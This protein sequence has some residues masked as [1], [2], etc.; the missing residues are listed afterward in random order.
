MAACCAACLVLTSPIAGWALAQE[1]DPLGRPRQQ[2]PP[3]ET[4]QRRASSDASKSDTDSH[5]SGSTTGLPD[6]P[7]SKSSNSSTSSLRDFVPEKLNRPQLPTQRDFAA[8]AAG[9]TRLT[10][11]Q[12]DRADAASVQDAANVQAENIQTTAADGE[13]IVAPHGGFRL[14]KRSSKVWEFGVEIS[15]GNGP[16]RGAIAAAPVP[17]EFP[18]QKITVLSEFRSPQVSSVKMKDFGGQGRQMIVNVPNL[19]PGETARATITMRLDRYD[20]LAPEQPIEWKFAEKGHRDGRLYLG[21]SPYIE[22]NH[23][24]FKELGTQIIN[25]DD[26]PWKQVESIYD[27]LQTNIQYEFDPTIHASLDALTNKKGDCEEFASLFIAL[28][29]SRGI[30]ARAVWCNDHTYPEFLMVTP[31]GDAVWLPCQLTTHE[32]IFGQMFDDR[33]ILQKGDKFTVVGETQPNR[34]LKPS[35]KAAAAAGS[36]QLKWVIQEV[37][38]ADVKRSNSPLGQ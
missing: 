38:P 20:I 23:K 34:Y 11:M 22:T 8:E 15:S 21:E 3:Q 37:N 9:A 12:Q 10:I 27:W 18:E 30:P 33:P 14:V 25:D 29:R 1:T 13:V 17:I 16:L 5:S 26:T 35:M 2:V 24:R 4:P 28:C 7:L 6:G 31:G 36:P 19:G 32:H